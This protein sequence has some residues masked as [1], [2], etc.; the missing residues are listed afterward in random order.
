MP[1]VQPVINKPETGDAERDAVMEVQE[2]LREPGD[3]D[4]ESGQGGDVEEFGGT[5]EER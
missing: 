4:S 1:D 3:E 2:D 5:G